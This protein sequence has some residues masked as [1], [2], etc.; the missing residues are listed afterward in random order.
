MKLGKKNI[1]WVGR[2][3]KRHKGIAIL[4]CVV[5]IGCVVGVNVLGNTKKVPET[6]GGMTFET[7]TLEKRDI[8]NSISVT[9]TIASADSRTLTSTLT[10]IDVESLNVAVGDTV[11]A[12]DVLDGLDVSEAKDKELSNIRNEKIGFVF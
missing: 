7:M 4:V 3:L 9:G 1:K 11:S 5:V 10:N 6:T 2:F 8:S 12:G